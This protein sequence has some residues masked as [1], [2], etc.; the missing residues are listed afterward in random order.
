MRL[1]KKNSTFQ[2]PL[3]LLLLTKSEYEISLKF[4]LIHLFG[5]LSKSSNLYANLKQ[6]NSDV[7]GLENWIRY[8]GDVKTLMHVHRC[9]HDYFLG[10]KQ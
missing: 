7:L 5:K 9:P 6:L 1:K 3:P 10:Q 8:L 4:Q 2:I